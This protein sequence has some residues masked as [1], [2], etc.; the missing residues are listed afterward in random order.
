MRVEYERTTERENSGVTTNSGPRPLAKAANM[1]ITPS[2]RT[3]LKFNHVNVNGY[4]MLTA[5]RENMEGGGEVGTRAPRR[6]CAPALQVCRG[7]CYAT[8]RK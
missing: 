8:A 7:S 1:V 5:N 6:S 2:D 4:A 3:Y